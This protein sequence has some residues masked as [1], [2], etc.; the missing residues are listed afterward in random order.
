M[1]LSLGDILAIVF[2]SILFLLLFGYLLFILVF[3]N[4]SSDNI[5]VEQMEECLRKN[6]NCRAKI[7]DFI[8]RLERDDVGKM[9]NDGM[10]E[11]ATQNTENNQTLF[12]EKDE[13][14]NDRILNQ[15]ESSM[16]TNKMLTT[17]VR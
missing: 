3:R 12:K 4:K 16:D 8:D 11:V 15:V 5:T 9:Y 14:Y 10:Q 17:P 7:S 6:P 1:A 13:V 2:G